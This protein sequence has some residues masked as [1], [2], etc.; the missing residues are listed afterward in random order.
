M[1]SLIKLSLAALIALAFAGTAMAVDVKFS[2]NIGS[3]FGLV[4]YGENGAVKAFSEYV[5]SYEANLRTT[6]GGGPLT[7]VNRLRPRGN[8]QA[9]AATQQTNS[10]GGNAALA[11]VYNEVWWK[12]ADAFTIGFG[13]FQGQAWSQ[14]FSGTYI[15]NH[16]L[17]APEYFMNWTGI[18]GID[19]EFNAGAMQIGLAIASE[20]RP[21]CG[22]STTKTQQSMT[23]H[24][25][26]KFG[27]IGVRANL[28]Q[29]TGTQASDDTQTGSGM[30]IGVQWSGGGGLAVGADFQSFTDKEF[31]AAGAEDRGRGG[32]GVRV[33]VA[34][35]TIGFH[36]LSETNN[37]GVKDANVD[38]TWLKVSY[39]L[40]V[41]DGSIIPEYTSISRTPKDG[42]A[43]TNTLLRIVGN[44]VY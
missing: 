35:V 15:I 1:R 27:D 38:Q 39:A 37:G 20:C 13:R 22:G 19:L 33:D 42:D 44:M 17:G 9:S 34:G 26:G 14:P 3:G 31:G 7:M 29:T 23:P 30:Q 6:I 40:K 12:P 36:S 16:P 11:D 25:A 21:S 41:G 18:D 43:V 4:S 28:P 32:L 8:Q 24:F 2:G 10:G 5:T